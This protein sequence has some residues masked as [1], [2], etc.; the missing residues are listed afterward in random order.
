MILLKRIVCLSILA[1]TLSGCGILNTF[2]TDNTPLPAS[3]PT[4]TIAT[5][6]T[7]LWQKSVGD[8]SDETYLQLNS[9]YANGVIY[10]VD[11]DTKVVATRANGDNVFTMKLKSSGKSGIGTNGS[12]LALVD[13]RANL[14]MLDSQ[15]GKVLWQIPVHNQVLATPVMTADTTYL[16]TID[17]VIAA[18]RNR[19]GALLWTYNHGSPTLVLRASSAVLLEG[20][21]LYAGFAD[22]VVVALDS[23][24]G[25]ELWEQ[26]IANPNG[27]AEIERMIDI[28]STLIVSNGVLFAATYQGQLAALNSRNGDILWHKPLSAYVNLALVNN[29]LIV[30]EADGTL[31][32]FNRL[33]GDVLWQQKNL[34]WRFLTGIAVLDHNLVLGDKEG[35]LHFIA[36]STGQYLNHIQPTKNPIYS[37]PLVNQTTVY[38]LDSAGKLAAI[39]A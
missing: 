16:K 3:L 29:A 36:A 35:Y 31:S 5:K 30:P 6:S 23:R 8:G 20:N 38:S 15:T 4:A 2:G 11:N 13:G 18:Y 33:N 22:G 7:V 9:A 28:D 12:Q 34:S 32:A 39:R 19:D 27:F 1:G 26:V 25:N 17:G 24:S 14:F 37:T 10:S 21:T